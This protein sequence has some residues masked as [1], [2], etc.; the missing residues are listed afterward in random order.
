M[1]LISY[2]EWEHM[3][4]YAKFLVKKQA[5]FMLLKLTRNKKCKINLRRKLKL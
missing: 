1:F 4:Q 3:D 5:N 2:Q